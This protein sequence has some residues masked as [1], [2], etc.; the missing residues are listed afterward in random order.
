MNNHIIFPIEVEAFRV[1]EDDKVLIVAKGREEGINRVQIQVSA[2]TIYPPMYLVV[3]E[4]INEPGYFPYTVQK[5][6]AYPSNIDYIQFQTGSGTKR[7]PI[8][9]VT[10]GDDDLKKLLASG[11]NQVVG[12]A[13]NVIDMNKAIVDATDKVRKMNIDFYSA[14]IKRSGVVSLSHFSDFQFFYVIM[15]YKE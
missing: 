4:P 14:E 9:D 5:T 6:I 12:Y 2:A 15:E 7:I 13:Y 8:T 1:G 10:E 3:G 11:E